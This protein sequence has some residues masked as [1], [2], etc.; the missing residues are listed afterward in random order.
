RQVP[1]A[2]AGIEAGFFLLRSTDMG[3][4]WA[5]FT[6]DSLKQIVPQT[7]VPLGDGKTLFGKGYLLSAQ[8]FTS[9]DGGMTWNLVQLPTLNDGSDPGQR[10]L[11]LVPDGSYYMQTAKYTAA[12]THSTVAYSIYH[13]SPGDAQWTPISTNGQLPLSIVSAMTSGHANA[14]WKADSSTSKDP[15]APDGFYFHAP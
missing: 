14:L 13:W 9:I 11:F 4:S 6:D 7:I 15:L 1:N 8:S 10:P 5:Q 3:Q 12:G 2:S